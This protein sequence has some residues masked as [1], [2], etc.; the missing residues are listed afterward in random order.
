MEEK[1]KL[2]KRIE[3]S[4]KIKELYYDKN[5]YDLYEMIK[6]DI[7]SNFKKQYKY[8]EYFYIETN[9]NIIYKFLNNKLINIFSKKQINNNDIIKK[10]LKE[11]IFIS[12][13]VS[14]K[15]DN[16][17]IKKIN[18]IIKKFLKKGKVNKKNNE[19]VYVE[20]KLE[21]VIL[22]FDYYNLYLENI[23]KYDF[24]KIDSNFYLS[25]EKDKII[26]IKK[27]MK[28]FK[29]I[30]KI[31][32]Q[33]IYLDSYNY[34]IDFY[35]N[36]IINN[37]QDYNKLNNLDNVVNVYTNKYIY[38][39]SNYN[40]TSIKDK[41][42]L[43]M[44]TKI[45]NNNIDKDLSFLHNE[46]KINKEY[47]CNIS[48]KNFYGNYIKAKEYIEKTGLS[49]RV[50][51]KFITKNNFE[52]L[53]KYLISDIIYFG[54]ILYDDY[55]N[56]NLVILTNRFYYLIKDNVIID[57]KNINKKNIE[58]CSI[59]FIPIIQNNIMKNTILNLDIKDKIR[60]FITY[61]SIL[62]LKIG[63]HAQ[64]RFNERISKND[65]FQNKEDVLKNDIY[66]YGEVMLGTYYLNSK[67]IKGKKFVYV[68]TNNEIV[69]IW[70][71]NDF[72]QNLSDRYFK[73]IK[74]F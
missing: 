27:D 26:I 41:N 38:T 56:S 48:I 19:F 64:Q 47:L 44:P 40:I 52:E 43:P 55:I 67:L 20:N 42:N 71:I 12:N 8:K 9:N 6:K 46:L 45:T 74:S 21:E 4:K 59:P 14:N 62:S 33:L 66:K 37:I 5:K 36:D 17:P 11:N 10:L 3:Y 16:I 69:S 65:I 54:T 23:I 34:D 58:E 57:I 49:I 18:E 2:P 32:N 1:I 39:I 60:D 22:V 15:F 24:K 61:E 73:Q 25:L 51:T 68:L 50:L 29:K 13:E 31:K 53:Y 70:K 30:E 28:D 7:F 63:N 72:I 35:K